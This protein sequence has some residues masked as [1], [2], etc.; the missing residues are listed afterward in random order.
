MFSRVFCLALLA[1]ACVSLPYAFGSEDSTV[2]A[3][4]GDGQVCMPRLIMLPASK[5]AEISHCT[6][7][8]V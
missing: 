8:C 4:A 5:L 7:R 3:N 6:Q 2:V 1:V